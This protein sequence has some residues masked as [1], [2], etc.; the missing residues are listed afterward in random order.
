MISIKY[1][2]CIMDRNGIRADPEK[3]CAIV[4]MEAPR[5]VTEVHR[6]LGMANHLGKF[7]PRLAEIS[8]LLLEL[9]N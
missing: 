5:S 7:S 8:Q 4:D 1:L 3:T 6:V 9:E 2:G